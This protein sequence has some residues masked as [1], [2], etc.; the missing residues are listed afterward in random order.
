MG[1]TAWK[2][3]ASGDILTA[4]DMNTY[5]RDNGRWMSHHATGGAPMCRV[6]QSTNYAH[7]S[8][9]AVPY[10]SEDFDPFAMHDTTTN[11][12]RITIPSGGGGK[13]LVGGA[14]RC[15]PSATPTD[16]TI[17]ATIRRS[18]TTSC[19]AENAV[20]LDVNQAVTL[21]PVTLFSA[22]AGDYFELIVEFSGM[23]GLFVSRDGRRSPEMW[24]I[25]VGE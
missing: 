16:G 25:W 15:D 9:N 12:S 2:T 7:T 6:Y 23:A 8:G 17:T 10:D 1:I 11:T 4:A 18:G 3:W 13:Y 14:L 24:A 22:S 5:V 19:A 21:A 20:N